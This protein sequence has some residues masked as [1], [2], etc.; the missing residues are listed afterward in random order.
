[1]HRS[2]C[3]HMPLFFAAASALAADEQVAP[4]AYKASLVCFNG[5]DDSGSSCRSSMAKIDGGLKV[6]TSKVSFGFPGG[7]SE[8]TWVYRG[9]KDGKDQYH[10]TRK[11]PSDTD[12]AATSEADLSFDGKRH[13]LFQ[14]ASQCIVV[15][16]EPVQK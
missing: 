6:V 9:Q 13:I 11:F 2:I 1:M 15:E 7:V 16:A 8:I 12:H 4:P 5:K 10:V 14:D 3:L